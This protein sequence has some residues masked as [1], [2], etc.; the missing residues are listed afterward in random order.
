MLS[1]MPAFLHCWSGRSADLRT[2]GLGTVAD[3]VR[4]V[5]GFVF[6]AVASQRQ[7]AARALRPSDELSSGMQAGLTALSAA[8]GRGRMP[9][10][11][12]TVQG[13]TVRKAPAGMSSARNRRAGNAGSS[14][15]NRACFFG[16]FLCVKESHSP[17]GARPGMPAMRETLFARTVV[18]S[19]YEQ[20]HASV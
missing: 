10:P 6:V 3:V 9:T 7:R 11:F 2:D 13:C 4:I 17:A 8:K 18:N 16:D 1:P 14:A 12:L 19:I 5:A 15:R 20:T